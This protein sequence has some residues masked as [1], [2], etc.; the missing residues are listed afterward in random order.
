M[1]YSIGLD[2]GTT[3]VGWACVNENNELLQYLN[4]CAFGVR[5]F[6]AAQ[7]AETTR[8]KRQMRRRYN[9]RKKRIQLLQEL[10]IDYVPK[11][12]FVEKTNQHFW[13]NENQFE[14]RALSQVLK[15]LRINLKE[16]P[17]I[18]HLRKSL[19]EG[20]KQD[21][22]L[23]YLAIHNLTKYRGH[24]LNTGRWTQKNQGFDFKVEC[25]EVAT[26]YAEMNGLEL[27]H[28]D[29]DK[30]QT[31][32]EDTETVRKDKQKKL[33][34]LSSKSF[35]P[36]WQFLLGLSVNAEKLFIE[37]ENRAHYKVINLK[38]V[39]GS[40]ELDEARENLSELEN[41]FVD[42]VYVLYQQILLKDLLQG[43]ECVAFSKVASYEK[44]QEDLKWFKKMINEANDEKLYRRFFI[45]S[46]SALT[47]YKKTPDKQ[48]KEKLCLLDQYNFSIKDKDTV[49]TA[50]T[51]LLEKSAIKHHTTLI[52]NIREG[53]FLARQKGTHN[54]AIPNQN[55]IYE[56]E[57][58][59]TNQQQ[60]YDFITEEFIEKVVEI[61]SFRI[62]YYI[63]PLAKNNQSKFAWLE[64][65]K[66][67]EHITPATFHD[68][69]NESATAEQFIKRM[70]NKCTY[71]QSEDVLPKQ[72]LL[73]QYFEVLNEL[74]AIQIRPKDAVSHSKYRLPVEAK[75]CV[76]EFGFKEYKTMTHKRLIQLLKEHQFDYLLGEEYEVFGTQQEGRFT[77]SLKSYIDFKGLFENSSVPFDEIMIER[78][79]EWL[80]IF[81]EKNIIKKKIKENYPKFPTVMIERV[82][83]KN[84]VGWG[85]LSK[86]LLDGLILNDG[87]TVI[88]KMFDSTLTFREVLGV[89]NSNLEELI[90]QK[91][92]SKRQTKKIAYSDVQEL[93]GSPA[94]KRGI[95][96]A[97]KVVEELTA[98]F[99]EPT[100]IML[101][102]AREE[103]TKKRT[104]SRL[105]KFKTVV[106]GL[107]KDEQVLKKELQPYL[108]QPEA[109]FK[110]NR[111]YLYLLQQGK[112]AYSGKSLNIH[113]L[114]N[115]EIDHIYPRSFVKDDSLDNLVLVEKSYNQQKGGFKMPLECMS[116][117][118]GARMRGIWKSWFDKGFMN[119][120]KFTRLCKPTF[121]E[122]DREQF[123][124]R[125]L[126]ETRQIIKNVGVLLEERFSDTTVHL[127]KAP[128]ISK[129]RKTLEIPKLRD[130]N[131][132]HHAIDALLNALLIN[133]A[134][135][136]YGENIFA[137]SFKDKERSKKLA[138][139]AQKR[140]GFFLFNS[141]LSEQINSAISKT[142]LSSREFVEEVYYKVPW[143]TTKKIGNSDEMFFDETLYSP[144]TKQ[145]KYESSKASKG[146]YDSVKNASTAVIKFTEK[147]K[148]KE[149]EKIELVNLTVLEEKQWSHLQ[150]DEKAMKLICRQYPNKKII[151]ASWVTNLFKY[152]KF[153]WQGQLFYL[154]AVKEL[155][156]AK[157]FVLPNTLLD[158]YLK[159]DDQTSIEELQKI[160]LMIAEEMF[161]QYPI[162]AE[163]QMP[164][165]VIIF[166][167]AIENLEQFK[168]EML[169]I[170]KTT[171]NNAT[172][173]DKL[174]SR[175]TRT[176]PAT[177]IKL[178]Y[179][180]ITGLKVRKPKALR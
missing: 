54:A 120:N 167:E 42:E 49:L 38:L 12:F 3:S 66:E 37:S 92:H 169:E 64:R 95:W 79:I 105:M 70:T 55:S 128:I 134:I 31:I 83:K 8:Q 56:I 129:F 36:L 147:N 137:F 67:N 26:S 154:A 91:N 139:V 162:F 16:I 18:Y 103:G 62:P 9:R 100:H 39:L 33:E 85:S 65:A 140:N 63:G 177:D 11:N 174:G 159:A 15:Q 149:V 58:I 84:F 77:S 23:I 115:Y 98:I 44:Y 126:V 76:I 96:Q 173:S 160:Y 73:Y 5:E 136:H 4:K 171:A 175:L 150:D 158:A 107:G 145:P 152:Q 116:A 170:F 133:H 166:A 93:A 22:R 53:T 61:V 28:L 127:V 89:K 21:I 156:L 97:V 69:V 2:I 81:N 43:H 104:Q 71:L 47:A 138:Q 124:A 117:S 146:V 108:K 59:L 17:T 72:S 125:Q 10:F 13:K 130:F 102:V 52:E 40:E 113:Q 34:E 6:E 1:K 51:K 41:Q 141:F 30:I 110:D 86:E 48:N 168:K 178:V 80:T 164:N 27:P 25:S 20:P 87:K 60:Y 32:F 111:F 121:S 57:K 176:V 78:L 144:K 131:N 153:I 143:Q 123:I 112:C 99:G 101:E 46:K 88:E 68:L 7:T 157:Q 151:S 90:K 118:E 114:L 74:N 106:D 119:Q 172:R 142:K 122:L 180:S 45:T 148:K 14:N 50:M 35:T 24:F 179:E 163:G 82:L 165:K 29:F 109:K 135:N 19:I 155:H 94:L 132:K 161:T 75:K